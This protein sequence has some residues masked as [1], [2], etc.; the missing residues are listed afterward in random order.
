[1]RLPVPALARPLATAA[2]RRFFGTAVIL[3]Y[4]RVASASVDSFRLS[5][6]PDHFA[7]QL[8]VVRTLGHPIGLR[9]LDRALIDGSVPRRSVCI[10]FDDGYADNLE[11]A[12]PLLERFDV[13]ATVF[14]ASGYLG[15][16]RGF[17]WDE[18]ENAL[19]R[20][21]NLPSSL[22]LTVRG[23]TRSWVL[24]ETARRDDPVAGRELCTAVADG[25]ETDLRRDAFRSLYQLLLAMPSDERQS[26]LDDIRAWMGE[27]PRQAAPRVL[28]AAD[29]L[30]LVDGGLIEVGAHTVTHP[31][32]PGLTSHRQR[33]EIRE[34]RRYLEDVLERPVT[35][36]A[37]PHGAYSEETISLVKEAGFERACSTIHDVAWQGSD[38]HRLPRFHVQDW[39]GE[40]FARHLDNWLRS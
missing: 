13:T 27:R 1:M 22:S 23:S 14:V 7:Q 18:L 26:A 21:E 10:T 39:D 17:W 19:L 32:L 34:S 6:T 38:R 31:C 35:S 12:K 20:A 11:Q 2:R 25:I 4:H 3:L 8:E 36:F 30:D 37:Y 9:E 24:S 40:T 29:L 15:S 33:E 16:E 5:V 28:S